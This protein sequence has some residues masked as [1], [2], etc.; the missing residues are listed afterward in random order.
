MEMSIM[1]LYSFVTG[2]YLWIKRVDNAVREYVNLY[3]DFIK[4]LVNPHFHQGVS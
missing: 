1:V 2:T 4:A 3:I